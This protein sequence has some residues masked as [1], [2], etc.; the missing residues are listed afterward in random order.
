V[1]LAL[2]ESNNK[3]IETSQKTRHAV[4]QDHTETCGVLSSFNALMPLKTV[5][6]YIIFQ[7]MLDAIP[8]IAKF[9]LVARLS[10]GKP[11]IGECPRFWQAQS[12]TLPM[13]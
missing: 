7:T 9:L 8:S 2:G 6:L 5:G 13:Q 12:V 3:T 11:P 1:V 10:I 4:R